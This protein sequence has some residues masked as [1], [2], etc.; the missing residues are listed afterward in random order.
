M[1]YV[2]VAFALYV[3]IS[4]WYIAKLTSIIDAHEN[5]WDEIEEITDHNENGEIVIHAHKV[6]DSEQVIWD[7]EVDEAEVQRLMALRDASN[8]PF[9]RSRL[10]E[11]IITLAH[12]KGAAR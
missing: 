9:E 2:G 12:L 11:E 10:A 5:S 4:S 1:I 8:D 7:G 6:P 3:L